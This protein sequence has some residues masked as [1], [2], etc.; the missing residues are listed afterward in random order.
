[1]KKLC[2]A[3]NKD[4]IIDSEDQ[5]FYEQI[6]VPVPTW[7]PECRMKRRFVWRNERNLYK[8]ICGLCNRSIVSIYSPDKPY[9]V[10]C[11]ECFHSDKW[12][13][14]SYGVDVDFSKPFLQQFKE[15]QNKVPRLY[16]FVF[17]NINSEYTNGSAFNKNCHLLFVSDHNEDSSYS[18]ALLNS[19]QTF[20]CMN[21]SECEL[22]Y[23]SISCKKCYK[24]LFSEDCSNSQDLIFC[25]NCTNCHDC[26]GSVNLKNQQYYIFNQQYSK[27]E[28]LEKKKEL[29]IDTYDGLLSLKEQSDKIWAKGIN[30]YM[31]GLNNVSILGDYVSNSKNSKFVFDSNSLEDA[32]FINHGNKSKSVYD[33]Y[34]VVDGTENSYE[35]VSAI[36][37]SNVKFSYCVWHG[38]DIEYADTC[39]NVNNLFGCVGLKKKQYCILNKQYSKEEYEDLVIKIKKHMDDMPYTDSKGRVYKYGEYFPPEFSPFSYNETAANEYFVLNEEQANKDGYSWKEQES[40]NYST[41]LNSKDLSKTIKDTPEDIVGKI[42]QCEHQG[43]CIHSC[44]TAFRITPDEFQFYQRL[45]IPIPRICPNCRHSN[46][47]LKHNPLNFWHRKCMSDGQHQG[48]VKCQ[49][50]FE[51]TYSP[52]RSEIVYCESC[53]QNEVS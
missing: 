7:C 3:C 35:I 45:D 26:I 29:N 43:K 5:G 15:L 34:V 27:E 52:E 6:K 50:E 21:S 47:F 24:V 48:E 9:T 51:T 18:Y 44:T 12:D 46:R 19:K 23:E 11:N 39:E 2:N 36:S 20:D 30:K 31:H 32:K 42:I 40:R 10:Y 38:F 4:F 16:A 41:D 13:P 1:M 8:N 37:L 25:K 14:I 53:Y 17:Q 28:Y 33:G 22:C 49:N